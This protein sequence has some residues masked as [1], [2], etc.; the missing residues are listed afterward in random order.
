[1]SWMSSFFS[2][3]SMQC[4]SS[5]NSSRSTWCS[6]WHRSTQF[7]DS[8]RASS[9][10]ST[11]EATRCL[12]TLLRKS[13]GMSPVVTIA[14]VFRDLTNTSVKRLRARST[15]FTRSRDLTIPAASAG[16]VCRGSQY[17][18]NPASPART[19]SD[20]PSMMASGRSSSALST[21]C[22]GVFP[23]SFSSSLNVMMGSCSSIIAASAALRTVGSLEN[24]VDSIICFRKTW[25]A[26]W[27]SFQSCFCCCDDVLAS[28]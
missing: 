20:T 6:K 12:L 19:P 23:P 4:F 27:C 8:Y 25:S 3:R 2:T 14:W 13:T 7:S 15:C 5:L 28:S 1:M 18:T 11:K 26:K 21:K 10:R 17:S 24:S 22:C 9:R 16:G